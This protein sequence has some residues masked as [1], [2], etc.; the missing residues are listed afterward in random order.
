MLFV[1]IHRHFHCYYVSPVLI[2]AWLCVSRVSTLNHHKIKTMNVSTIVWNVVVH[3]YEYTHTRFSRRKVRKIEREKWPSEM[4]QGKKRP[5][6]TIVENWST[7][8]RLANEYDEKTNTE[9]NNIQ[10]NTSRTKRE[11]EKSSWSEPPNGKKMFRVYA[12][13]VWYEIIEIINLIYK[14]NEIAT[15]QPK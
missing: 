1:R 7:R 3:T 12:L 5:R 13:T 15:R 2:F 11:I 4:K 6:P 9:D 8:Q 14:Y 10:S